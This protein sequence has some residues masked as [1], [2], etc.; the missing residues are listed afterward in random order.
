MCS[1][2]SAGVPDVTAS[3]TFPTQPLFGIS[4]ARDLYSWLV[5]DEG[6]MAFL[7]PPSNT[8][9][10]GQAFPQLTMPNG[11]VIAHYFR[12]SVFTPTGPIA[13]LGLACSHLRLHMPWAL[14]GMLFSP[15]SVG[16]S[17]G[18]TYEQLVVYNWNTSVTTR[19]VRVILDLRQ[20]TS[21]PVELG[22]SCE[23]LQCKYQPLFEAS[24]FKEFL[25]KLA[26][27]NVLRDVVAELTLHVVLLNQNQSSILSEA[28][29]KFSRNRGGSISPNF[30]VEAFNVS[31]CAPTTGVKHTCRKT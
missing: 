4:T 2:R 31:P 9:L 21:F 24:T 15:V 29:I 17:A 20:E 19:S 30:Y 13:H 16:S 14:S 1:F 6:L 12:L 11:R 8:A 22:F 3:V 26:Q 18:Q 23:S 28:Y 5:A 7:A 10:F 27:A 25:K